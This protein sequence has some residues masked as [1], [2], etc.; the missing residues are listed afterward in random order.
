MTALSPDRT[1]LD[2]RRGACPALSMPM[3]T[4]DG[5]LARMAL[6]D[7]I[8]VSQ[9][10][11]VCRLADQH[12]NGVLDISA[13]GNLQVRGLADETAPLLE[14]DIRA[15]NLP[16][17]ESL[18]I[19]IPPLAGRDATEI[20]DPRPLA[21]VIRDGARNITGLAPKMSVVVDGS[22]R[23]RL[24]GLLADIRLSAIRT[25]SGIRWRLLLGGTE[26]S[27]RTHGTYAEDDAASEALGLL[28]R[29]AE[30]GDTARGRDLA[31]GSMPL[32]AAAD[33]TGSPFDL[34][35]L[36]DG[37]YGLGIGLPF[38]Q[39]RARALAGLCAEA[40]EL[41]I[42]SVRPAFDHSL[43]FFFG[44]RPACEAMSRLASMSGFIT[45]AADARSR[46]AACPGRPA[47]TSASIDTHSLA[48]LAL[49]SLGDVLD[50]SFRLHVA[51]CPK[52]CAH[53]Q[54]AS[55]ALCGIEGGIAFSTGKAS[56]QAFISRT[57][58]ETGS[59]LRRIA[60]LVRSERRRDE[61]SAACMARL[62]ESRLASA[63]RQ[64]THDH[65]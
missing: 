2:M 26:A 51:G 29:L 38:G 10:S 60:A 13:R 44:D 16:L 40:E 19:D 55:L 8:G 58:A 18:A 64:E 27:G 4:G 41:G 54:A 65:L 46:I 21:A 53:P 1:R 48:D 6:T 59:S 24:S 49:E 5:L 47:C 33:A 9:L 45:S 30:L 23:L 15:M 17:R 63:S 61:T 34:F 14:A 3:R 7:P 36:V 28:Q 52:G 22:G 12:G 42:L 56:D 11:A 62:G 37:Q 25:D 32:N 31:A 39:A 35:P 43:F 50:G 57:H 20:A